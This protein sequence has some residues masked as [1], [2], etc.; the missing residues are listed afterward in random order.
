MGISLT[1]Y[2]MPIFWWALLL[3]L[4]F[5]V[6]LGWTPVSGRISVMYWVEPVTDFML[7]DALLSDEPGAF[8]SALSPSDPARRRAGHHA[9][10]GDRAA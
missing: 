8:G 5:S 10:G 4:L 3:I 2:S 6:N 7:I 1:G 9:A